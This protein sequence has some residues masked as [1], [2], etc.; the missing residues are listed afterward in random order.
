MIL[1]VQLIIRDHEYSV[2]MYISFQA[3]LVDVQ[4]DGC[5]LAT[6]KPTPSNA[7]EQ[8]WMALIKRGNCQFDVKVFNAQKKKYYG[9]IVYN[10]ESDSLLPMGGGARK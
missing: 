2:L 4:S 9:A 3:H 6:F 5:D 1:I 10:D 8:H 7:T